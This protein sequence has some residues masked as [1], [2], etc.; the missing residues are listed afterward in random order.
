MLA[1]ELLLT[2]RELLMPTRGAVALSL[3]TVLG[4]ICCFCRAMAFSIWLAAALRVSA[5]GTPARLLPRPGLDSRLLH[6]LLLREVLR[7][8]GR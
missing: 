6:M 4:R 1:A 7:T 2:L 3:L 5:D 8:G